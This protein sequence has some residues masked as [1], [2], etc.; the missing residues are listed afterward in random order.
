[1][2]LSA[3]LALAVVVAILFAERVI[4][5]GQ[6][7]GQPPTVC[8]AG[9]PPPNQVTLHVYNATDKDGLARAVAKNLAA[10]GFRIV[11]VGN[12]PKGTRITGV[13][14]VRY[15][16]SASL[17]AR[18][19]A[20]RFPGAQLVRDARTD[21]TVDVAIG[22]AYRRMVTPPPTPATPTC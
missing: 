3:F 15:G 14:Q 8:T 9:P 13:A 18:T 17:A 21:N 2:S 10:Q 6:P 22:E 19:V 11:G 12:D 1:M 20:A 7:V 5:T 16:A 4:G